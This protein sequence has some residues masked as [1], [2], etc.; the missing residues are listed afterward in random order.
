MLSKQISFLSRRVFSSVS[1]N[2]NNEFK[3]AK[4]FSEIPTMTMWK[5]IKE[6]IPGGRYHGKSVK[7]ILLLMHK[8]F[9]KI[10]R[11]PALLGRPEVVITYDAEDFEKV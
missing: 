2:I 9:G 10:L 11:I 8:D 1:S 3:N 4:P 6:S 5:A 7:D